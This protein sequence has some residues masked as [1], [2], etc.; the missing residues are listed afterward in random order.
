MNTIIMITLSLQV[1]TRDSVASEDLPFS[2][3]CC[4]TESV[5]II[6]KI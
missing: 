1:V 3:V 5:N 2:I 4:D 6:L